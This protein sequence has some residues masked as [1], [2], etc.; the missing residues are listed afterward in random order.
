VPNEVKM[1]LKNYNYKTRP[2][3]QTYSLE[4]LYTQEPIVMVSKI[5]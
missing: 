5:S 4:F 1:L 2:I 3:V